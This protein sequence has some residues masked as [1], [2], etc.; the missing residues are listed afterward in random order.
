MLF[1]RVTRYNEISVRE[2]KREISIVNNRVRTQIKIFCN[3]IMRKEYEK[4]KYSTCY[5]LDVRLM[6]GHEAGV[7]RD[8]DGGKMKVV[9]EHRQMIVKPLRGRE[10]QL[11]RPTKQ[12]ANEARQTFKVE[13]ESVRGQGYRSLHLLGLWGSSAFLSCTFA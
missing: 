1:L 12:K 9:E 8:G 6:K 7:N 10:V 11:Q 3:Y 5:R 2:Q 4:R 13:H